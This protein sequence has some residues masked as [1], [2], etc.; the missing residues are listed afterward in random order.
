MMIDI[1]QARPSACQ[2]P[3]LL[4]VI[5]IIKGKTGQD[6]DTTKLEGRLLLQ[7]V[8]RACVDTTALGN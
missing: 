4:V 6:F 8:I 1:A 2:T 7:L 3:M 5:R